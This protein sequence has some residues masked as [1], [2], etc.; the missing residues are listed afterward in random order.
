MRARYTFDPPPAFPRV[1]RF[2]CS[3]PDLRRARS[4]TGGQPANPVRVDATEPSRKGT[5]FTIDLLAARTADRMPS[6]RRASASQTGRRGPGGRHAPP[7][8]P[9][10]LTWARDRFR[11]PLST[12]RLSIL[13]HSGFPTA[14][15]PYHGGH[16]PGEF[17]DGGRIVFPAYSMFAT[18]KTFLLLLH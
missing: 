6:I 14:S 8:P 18:S 4:E 1:A 10:G 17:Q 5:G 15:F 2:G 12:D 3:Q 13:R 9:G 11:F 16:R 7:Q